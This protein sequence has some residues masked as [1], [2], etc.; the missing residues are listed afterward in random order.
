MK[1]SLVVGMKLYAEKRYRNNTP[2]IVEYI[3]SKIGNKYF[4]VE[5]HSW[6]KF[7][8]ST[9]CYVDK[10]YSQNNKQLYK[11]RE[12]IEEKNERQQLLFKI[13]DFFTFS[14]NLLSLDQLKRIKEIISEK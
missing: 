8:I 4:E 5:G 6:Y 2:E 13:K 9:L 12:E 3:V 1:H 11:S 7:Q 10:N 14:G